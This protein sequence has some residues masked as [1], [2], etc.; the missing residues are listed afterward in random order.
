MADSFGIIHLE[1][2]Q[3]NCIKAQYSNQWD[4]LV[5][6]IL[7]MLVSLNLASI[8]LKQLTQELRISLEM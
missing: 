8:F 4:H 3:L 6:M 5:D 1:T 7:K 2:E